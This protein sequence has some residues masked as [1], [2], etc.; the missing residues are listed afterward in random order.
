MGLDMYLNAKKDVPLEAAT[1]MAKIDNGK[2]SWDVEF[3]DYLNESWMGPTATAKAGDIVTA[4]ARVG[5]WRKANAIHDWFVRNVQDGTDNCDEYEVSA[6]QLRQ[7]RED[8]QEALKAGDETDNLRPTE[9]FF[10][11]SSDIKYMLDD[12]EGTIEQID[13]VLEKYPDWVYT[14]QSSW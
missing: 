13:R 14:Y 5:Y 6:E 9:G 10:F 3:R 8:C 11:G 2:K 7:L 4:V 1:M 12:C